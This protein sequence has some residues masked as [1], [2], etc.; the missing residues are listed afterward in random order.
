[1]PSSS[2]RYSTRA[3]G[4]RS[5]RYASFS[6]ELLF[7]ESSCSCALASTNLSGCRFQ[8]SSRNFFSSA[9]ISIQSLRGKPKSEKWSP[10][11]RTMEGALI[12]KSFGYL[13]AMGGGAVGHPPPP[14]FCT[15]VDSKGAESALVSYTFASVHFKVLYRR[16]TLRPCLTTPKRRAAPSIPGILSSPTHKPHCDN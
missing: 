3:T 4:S 9:D 11:S 8:L 2:R 5:T 16:N 6:P 15:S 14:P 7:S 12:E 13:G 10:V 1:M